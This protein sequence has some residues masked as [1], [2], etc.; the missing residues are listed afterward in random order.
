MKSHHKTVLAAVAFEA[1]LGAVGW[2]LARVAGVPVSPRLALSKEIAIRSV[3]ALIPMLALLAFGVRTHW[4]PIVR[5]RRQVES[6]VRQLFVGVPWWGLAAVALAAGVGEE[7]LFRGALQPLAERWLG[8]AIGLVAVSVLFGALH[9]ASVVYFIVATGVGIYLGW[10][11]QHFGDLVTPIVVHAVY[12][13]A[14][15]C[16]LCRTALRPE[17]RD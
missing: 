16:V 17:S 8:A 13:F 9:A 4:E 12:D 7:L 3:L 1:A 15:L 6:L 5:L 2:A 10:L 14:A 11:A